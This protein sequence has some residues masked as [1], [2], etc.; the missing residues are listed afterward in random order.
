MDINFLQ[1]NTGRNCDNMVTCLEIGL[2]NNIDFI[3]LQEPY[4]RDG[5]T[6][7]HPAYN[8]ILPL[9]HIIPRVA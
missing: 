8:V 9:N 2:E 3:L 1:N 4:I 5:S 6:I 7:S